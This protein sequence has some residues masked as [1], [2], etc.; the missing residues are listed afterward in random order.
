MK[1]TCKNLGGEFV[2]EV[3]NNTEAEIK[4]VIGTQVQ[5]HP[6][7]IVLFPWDGVDYGVIIQPPQWKLLDW[8]P[9]ERLSWQYLSHNPRAISLLQQY[10]ERI[11]W[12]ML[13]VNS[14]GI[15]FLKENPDKIVW[16]QLAAN[17]SPDA[18][19]LLEDYLENG[20]GE[21]GR[22]TN[23]NQHYLFWT[24]LSGNP[25]ALPLLEKYI[26]HIKW[27][28]LLNNNPSPDLIPFLQKHMDEH[29]I[30]GHV[31]H[32]SHAIKLIEKHE[33]YINWSKLSKNPNAIHL[34]ENHID[35]I[36]WWELHSSP[37]VI[38][39][40]EKHADKITWWHTLCENEHAMPILLKHRDKIN[41]HFFC[42]N[43]SPI[44]ME[45]IEQNLN[46][47]DSD[48]NLESSQDG[49]ALSK[50]PSAL[51]LLS[52]HPELIQWHVLAKHPEIFEWVE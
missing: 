6:H 35:R 31:S 11:D 49:L 39:M 48:I 21:E 15:P 47:I 23:K 36:D 1:L 22:F 52:R 30:V 16:Y 43:T 41:W 28:D 25:N 7:R 3:S 5:V 33:N 29:E 38:P 37:N 10:P 13:S 40:L 9:L 34:L 2:I 26:Q 18:I 24:R 27:Y 46:R 32:H 12:V 20:G 42:N 45:L 44:A 19:P 51:P 17:S 4:K 8:I 14:E 50:N